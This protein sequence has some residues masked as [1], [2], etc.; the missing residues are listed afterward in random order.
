MR[1]K[2]NQD[3]CLGCGNCISACPEQ[4]D[5]DDDSFKAS[6]ICYVNTKRAPLVTELVNLC[7]ANA[8]EVMEDYK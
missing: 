4:F 6:A 8:I 2:V 7:K 5:W 3:K 1:I